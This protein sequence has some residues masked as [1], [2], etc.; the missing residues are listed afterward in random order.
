MDWREAFPR[1]CPT[2][3]VQSFINNGVRPSLIPLIM[4]YFED[5][6]MYVQWHGKESSMR[7]MPAGGPKGG[8][9]RICSYLSQNN[10]NADCFKQNLRFMFVDNFTFL[11]MIN[12]LNVGMASYIVRQQVPSNVPSSHYIIPAENLKTQK[13][14][15]NINENLQFLTYKTF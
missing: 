8:T 14:L 5:R 12:W 1:Q 10:N 13:D 3:G 11:E 2:L 9:V 6:Q 4:S 7:Q 15:E